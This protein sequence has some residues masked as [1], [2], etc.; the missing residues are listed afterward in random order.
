MRKEAIAIAM[1]LP[2]FRLNPPTII[3]S[4]LFTMKLPFKDLILNGYELVPKAYRQQFRNC[5]KVSSQCYVEFAWSKEQLF[6]RW[7]HSQKV[8][9]SHNG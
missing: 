7:C 6:D 5:E 8:D 1:Y 2:Y 4:S 9:K 3:L